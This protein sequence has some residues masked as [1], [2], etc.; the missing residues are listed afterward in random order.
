M[1]NI[2]PE[3]NKRMIEAFRRIEAGESSYGKEA[4]QLGIGQGTLHRRHMKHYEKQIEASKGELMRIEG[5]TKKLRTDFELLEPKYQKKSEQLQKEFQEKKAVLENKLQKLEDGI[6]EIEARFAGEGLSFHQ[7]VN[8]LREIRN[9]AASKNLLSA[10]EKQLEDEISTSKREAHR[11]GLAI[12]RIKQEKNRLTKERAVL[13]GLLDADVDLL[14]RFDEKI[15]AKEHEIRSLEDQRG[16]IQ[17]DLIEI[18]TE[19]RKNKESLEKLRDEIQVL[20]KAK[21]EALSTLEKIHVEKDLVVA[22]TKK[23][24]GQAKKNIE[25]L[26]ASSLREVRETKARILEEVQELRKEK[27]KLQAEQALIETAV[28]MKVEEFKEA[29]KRLK[30]EAGRETGEDMRTGPVGNLLSHIPKLQPIKTVKREK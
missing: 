6:A 24:V 10:Q 7:A 19:L 14:R 18:Q 25:E 23:L 13:Q 29:K 30:E 8:M 28:K 1:R 17:E 16:K 5:Q 2:S 12:R 26:K 3:L 20:G 21:P 9:L 4:D 27:E 15:T 11:E 22:E